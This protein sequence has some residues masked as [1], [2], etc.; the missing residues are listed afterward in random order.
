MVAEMLRALA[1]SWPCARRARSGRFVASLG[2]APA[3]TLR[4][5]WALVARGGRTSLLEWAALGAAVV[6]RW[7]AAA[8][9]S[10]SYGGAAAVAGRR[11]GESPAMS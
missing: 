1:A 4:A 8:A 10:F 7:C 3:E 11:S 5:C 6:A 9:A 2:A